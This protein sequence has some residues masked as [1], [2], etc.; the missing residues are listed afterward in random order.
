VHNPQTTLT[1]LA[2]DAIPLPV[3]PSVA[4]MRVD[5]LACAGVSEGLSSHLKMEF[6]NAPKSRIL[7]TQGS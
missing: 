6:P 7:T 3:F 2:E 1:I 5:L 4:A